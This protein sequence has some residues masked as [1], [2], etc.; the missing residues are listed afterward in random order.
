M[1]TS[2]LVGEE[3]ETTP[4]L[5]PPGPP[6]EEERKTGDP[7]STPNNTGIADICPFFS[8]PGRIPPPLSQGSSQ[9]AT[10]SKI[11]A[12][13][14]SRPKESGECAASA[15]QAGNKRGGIVEDQIPK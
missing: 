1:V 2:R 15:W 5:H 12:N 14:Q 8:T 4:T 11:A 9:R 3:E 7:D 10:P 13:L 6:R